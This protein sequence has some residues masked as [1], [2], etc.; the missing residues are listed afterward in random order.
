M[1]F[2]PQRYSQMLSARGL[3]IRLTH[4][5]KARVLTT[6][7]K[8][9]VLIVDTESPNHSRWKQ[10][11][12][13]QGH[14]VRG[15]KAKFSSQITSDVYRRGSGGNRRDCAEP[16]SGALPIESFEVSRWRKLEDAP[17]GYSI[18]VAGRRN[19]VGWLRFKCTR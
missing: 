12:C 10:C 18:L 7:A 11:V 16:W 2:D 19:P 15:I 4:R 1:R 13:K 5:T 8:E 9:P 17:Y 3:S 6:M 14:A